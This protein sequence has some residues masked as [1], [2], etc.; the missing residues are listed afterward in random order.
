MI[1]LLKINQLY[2]GDAMQHPTKDYNKIRKKLQEVFQE[3]KWFL[4]WIEKC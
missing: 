3:A 4:F 2:N 1:I